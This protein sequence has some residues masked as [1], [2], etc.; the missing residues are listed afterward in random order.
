MSSCPLSP[1]LIIRALICCS[2]VTNPHNN[3]WGTVNP[4]SPGPLPNK[5]GKSLVH[6]VHVLDMVGHGWAWPGLSPP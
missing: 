4:G 6:L 3:Y 1:S 5:K 2:V